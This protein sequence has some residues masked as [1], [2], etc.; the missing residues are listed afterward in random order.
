MPI[1]QQCV[2]ALAT[3][4]DGRTL[5]S[6]QGGCRWLERGKKIWFLSRIEKLLQGFY[7]PSNL[8][9]YG[10]SKSGGPKNLESMG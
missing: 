10:F 8:Y 7:F 4:K 6:T 1:F 2:I 9:G 3:L 5:L